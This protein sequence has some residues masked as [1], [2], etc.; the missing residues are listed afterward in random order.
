M[1]P[2]RSESVG[3]SIRLSSALPC[4]VPISCTPRSAMVRA[5]CAS[6]S[7][8][9]SSITITS[10][11]WFSTASIITSCWRSGW[12]TCMRRARPMAGCGT[13]PSP[14]ISLEVSTITTRLLS[15]ST[16]AASRS[17]VVLPTPGGP[18]ISTLCPLST[19]S[20]MMSIVPYTARPTRQV[21]PTISPRRLRMAE[22]RCSVRS[23]PARLSAS[24]A[25][26]PATTLSSS[27]RVTSR[28]ASGTSPE[29]KRAV[30]I[31]PRS[32]T[33]SSSSSVRP[34]ASSRAWMCCGRICFSS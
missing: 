32:S 24:K 26:T 1:P 14:P 17:M 30:G 34:S 33:I 8:P 29:T 19:R 21:M 16:R 22:M 11:L 3:L 31:R 2:T 9:I 10:G 23:M 6:S 13:S 4:A 20:W 25:P 28:S 15:A 5:A 12:L 27:T 7:R 18:I